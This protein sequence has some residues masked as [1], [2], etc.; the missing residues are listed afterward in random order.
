VEICRER[1][2]TPL[3]AEF[4]SWPKPRNLDTRSQ[5]VYSYRIFAT[6]PSF[7]VGKALGDVDVQYVWR[8][9][10]DHDIDLAAR[11]SWCE[12][13]DPA[14]VAKAA[15]VVGLYVDP[16]AK[17]I[18][19]CVDE[20]PSIQALERAQGYLKLPNGHALTG[21][22][23]DYIRRDARPYWIAIFAPGVGRRPVA[24]L[25]VVDG[26]CG[27]R[28]ALQALA[29][30]ARGRNSWLRRHLPRFYRFRPLLFLQ[31]CFTVRLCRAAVLPVGRVRADGISCT[32]RRSRSDLIAVPLGHSR[33]DEPFASFTT[34]T[35]AM[36]GAPIRKCVRVDVNTHNDMSVSLEFACHFLSNLQPLFPGP[37]HLDA[38]VKNFQQRRI[39]FLFDPIGSDRWR[40]LV[41]N[42]E[43]SGAAKRFAHDLI[44]SRWIGVSPKRWLILVRRGNHRQQPF[45][46]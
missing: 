13:N 40:W 27:E 29:E 28:S 46:S 21:Q 10:R 26:G 5:P 31:R 14:F 33:C 22:S 6:N 43:R 42:P 25:P 20:K 12:S 39:I 34:R 16:P 3:P 44:G 36:G 11:K 38:I 45:E 2:F 7:E 18:V 4:T 8:F 23:H 30:Q 9:L 37:W 17:A 24:P 19:L 35:R 32:P 1:N 15:D 41:L